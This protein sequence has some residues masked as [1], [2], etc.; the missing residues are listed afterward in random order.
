MMLEW[1]FINYK[2]IFINKNFIFCYSNKIKKDS[3]LLSD[4]NTKEKAKEIV[5]RLKMEAKRD[6][7]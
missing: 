7:K 4:L 2:Y 6:Y 1:Q 3:M 5:E